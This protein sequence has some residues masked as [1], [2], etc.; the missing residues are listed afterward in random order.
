MI[1]TALVLFLGIIMIGS[2]FS[3]SSSDA[4]LPVN[5][6]EVSQAPS[7]VRV[8]EGENIIA[9]AR[10]LYTTLDDPSNHEVPTSD[11]HDGVAKLIL[12]RTDGT[13]GC[14]GT[15]ANDG[16]HVITAAHCVAD[17]FGNYILTSGSATFEG[18]S[19]SITILIDPLNSL[20]H[21]NYDGDFIKGN[22]IAVLKLVSPTPLQVPGIPHATSDNSVSQV[23]DKNG[24]GWSGFLETGADPSTYPFGTE[25]DG[26]NKYDAFADTM[27]LAL[28]LKSNTDFMPQAIYQYDSDD[29]DTEH[30][31]FDFFFGISNLG[32]DIAEVISAPGDSGGPTI[33]NGELVGVTSYGITLEFTR[34][35]PPRTSDCTTEGKSPILDSSCGEFAGDTRVSSYSNFIDSV[36]NTEP[37]NPPTAD[38]NGPYSGTEDSAIAFDGTGSSDLDGDPLTYS[39][40]FGDGSSGS[41]ATPTHTY[42]WGETFTVTLTVSDGK[43]GSDTATTT[44]TVSEVNDAPTADANG[45][46]SGTVNEAL[47]FDGSGSSDPDN[48]DGTTSNDQTLEYSWDFGDGN[49]GSGVSP[50]HTYTSTGTFSVSLIVSD[51]TASDTSTTAVTVNETSTESLSTE[52]TPTLK[53][54]GPWN[55]ISFTVQVTDET[56]NAVPNV[57]VQMEVT[58]PSVNG[59]GGNTFNFSGTTD[60]SGSVKFT[61]MKTFS[62]VCY[63]T[64]ITNWQTD[65]GAGE[66]TDEAFIDP[67]RNL[68]TCPP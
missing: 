19:E 12:T 13:F 1:K 29:G 28:G 18:N 23:V 63:S 53:K 4:L 32:L 26:Q 21:P 30:D 14:S 31:A 11:P 7:H 66:E 45:P 20:S 35:P 5:L 52:I 44:A 68:T 67:N 47:T 6:P 46:Y 64:I 17:D 24:Y 10:A 2:T 22:D 42:S 57:S 50:S 48:L 16:L 49:T 55:D 40:D 3:M 56:N 61:I 8:I 65:F 39:W 15:L 43:G 59:D 54:K 60:D 27:Y 33:L 62:E 41:G 38:A 58:R 34:G 9:Y 25:R 36:L 37:N 51:G